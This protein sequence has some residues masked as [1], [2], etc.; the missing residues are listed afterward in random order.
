MEHKDISPRQQD[1]YKRL[2][3]MPRKIL[4][5]YDVPHVA[6][7]VLHD[8]C[9]EKGFNFIKA[10]YFIDNPDFDSLKGIGGFDKSEQHNGADNWSD[11]AAFE[12]HLAN[13]CSFN[14]KVRSFVKPSKHKKGALTKSTL[15]DLAREL[16]MS[17]ALLYTWNTK[18]DNHAI[19]L[20][21]KGDNQSELTEEAL[22]SLALL[23]FCPV[24]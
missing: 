13:N 5:H 11:R 9:G 20:Y 18:H 19:F 24:I 7:L 1:L 12:K 21:Q 17:D 22:A 14:K 23:A 15:S 6:D 16:G 3:D 4:K 2:A 10:A 8:L